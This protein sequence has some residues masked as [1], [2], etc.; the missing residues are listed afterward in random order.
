[1]SDRWVEVAW[2]PDGF[3][4]SDCTEAPRPPWSNHKLAHADWADRQKRHRFVWL[5]WNARTRRLFGG[6]QSPATTQFFA[7]RPDVI[8]WVTEIQRLRAG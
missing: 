7:E 8:D 5:K 2:H 6:S 4:L 1:M 3:V